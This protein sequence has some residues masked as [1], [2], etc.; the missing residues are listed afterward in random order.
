MNQEK[1]FDAWLREL[2]HMAGGSFSP[3]DVEWFRRNAY[4]KDL[5][6]QAALDLDEA[7]DPT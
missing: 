4:A 5:S 3:A 2:E 6:P 7:E 1:S